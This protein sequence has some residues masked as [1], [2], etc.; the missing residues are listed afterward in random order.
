MY[1]IPALG[2]LRK[3][4]RESEVSLSY[5]V[6]LVSGLRQQSEINKQQK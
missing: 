5:I 3:E 1:T 6:R 4:D 2:R